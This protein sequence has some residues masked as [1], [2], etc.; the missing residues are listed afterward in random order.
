MDRQGRFLVVVA[1]LVF[2]LLMDTISGQ[3]LSRDI[4][5]ESPAMQTGEAMPRDG[6]GRI[7]VGLHRRLERRIFTISL[8]MRWT[9][10][11]GLS[12]D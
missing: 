11:W 4:V 9:K 3:E 6:S 12:R 5:L 10:Y 7:T 2:G 8:S 1:G